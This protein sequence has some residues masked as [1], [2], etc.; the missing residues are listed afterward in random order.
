MKRSLIT[1]FSLLKHNRH[2]RDVF[3]A[4]TV[5]LLTIGM[6]VVAIPQQ[7]FQLTHDSLQVAIAMACEGIAM[8]V[9]LL[10]GG[11]LADR[12]DR[13][14]LILLARS[15]CAFG[16]MGLAV[17]AMLTEP[18]LA[19]IYA[20][21]IWDGF[22]GA[23]GVTAMMSVMPM[24]VG[25]ENLLQARAIS[26]VAVRLATVISPAV[27]GILIASTG[28]VATF[29]VATIGT[30]LTV[31][32]LLNL[33]SL[34]PKLD[35]DRKAFSPLKQLWQGI[36]FLLQH[37]VV[38]GTVLI[39]TV[40][41]FSSAIRITF[42]ALIEDVFHA[43]AFELGLLYSAVPLGAT[44]G[45]LFSGWVA[46]LQR[47]G[48]TMLYACLGTFACF[49]LMGCITQL[50]FALAILVVFGYLM[51]VAN[52]LQYTIVQGHT[53]D[54]YLGRINAI[55][56]AQDASGDAV[57]TSALGVLGKL[58]SLTQSLVTFGTVSLLIGLLAVF[59]FESVQKAPL[60]DPS[61]SVD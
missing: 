23:I 8:F 59:K 13:K 61:L 39:G 55:W 2:F 53:P 1:D 21:S 34:K 51:A 35:L 10:F 50:S 4:R 52:L 16:F 15:L 17:N 11:L 20:L 45:A 60:Q 27:G 43:G 25:R 57:A 6:L 44:L 19:T 56:L 42:P 9:G 29:W 31:L 3:I 24:I 14:R 22:F 58:T 36:E 30:V 32:L 54:E 7:V 49:I 18:H 41:T 47:P 12:Y 33:P 48:Q 26:M 40:L 28:V 46:A 37:K 5:S 38:G